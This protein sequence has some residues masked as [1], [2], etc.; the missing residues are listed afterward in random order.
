M[1]WS[2]QAGIKALRTPNSSFIFDRRLRSMTLWAVFLAIFFPALLVELGGFLLPLFVFGA[3]FFVELLE[4][5][6]D[7]GRFSRI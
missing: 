4:P 5:E 2:V 7:D 1:S 6:D 3:A